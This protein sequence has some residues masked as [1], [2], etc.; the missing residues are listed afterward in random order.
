LIH[1]YY[2]Y[3]TTGGPAGVGV[4]VGRAVRASLVL[5]FVIDIFVSLALWGSSVTVKVA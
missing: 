1:S 4:S 5:I 2:G 3:R